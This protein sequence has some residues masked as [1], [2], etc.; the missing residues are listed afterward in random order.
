LFRRRINSRSDRLTMARGTEAKLRKKNEK[1]EA[2]ARLAEEKKE[3]VVSD[4]FQ[5][6]ENDMPLPPGME[7]KEEVED[8][9]EGEGKGEQVDV[10]KKKAKKS[11]KKK[12]AVAAPIPQPAPAKKIKTM[13]LVL[14]VLLTGSTLLPALIYAGDWMG[15]MVQK[16]HIMGALGHKLGIG[17]TPKKRVLSFYE[18]H[19]PTKIEE[20]PKIMAKYY[21][22]YPKLVK[23][24]ER[25][26][27]D[28]GYFQSWEQDE[29]PMKLAMEQL[30]D[31]R[32]KLGKY[33]MQYAPDVVKTGVRNAQGNFKFL[34]K[35]GNKVWKKQ[36]WPI[37]EPFF[38][39]PDGGAAQ[40]RKDRDAARKKKGYKT[41]S[42]RDDEEM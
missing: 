11:K 35:K 19:D 28:Y 22:D 37:L 16:H 15:N 33:W 41:K 34:Y 40:K 7:S 27:Q 21:G 17:A 31:T 32:E 30:D 39:V 9:S 23:R 14:L 5:Y 13:P 8:E 36:V 4:D 38:G 1:K 12:K 6:A 29:A 24:L 25:R 2:R 26:Y 20:V 18:K 10:E 42:Y 3:G